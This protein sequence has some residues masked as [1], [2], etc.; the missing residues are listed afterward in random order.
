MSKMLTALKDRNLALALFGELFGVMLFQFLAGSIDV[1]IN[2]DTG[3]PDYS[4][5]TTVAVLAW[6][7]GIVF[8]VLVYL[9]RHTSGGHLNPV[10]TIAVTISGH[11]HIVKGILYI[12]VQ[13]VGGIIGAGGAHM[14]LSGATWCFDSQHSGFSGWWNLFGWEIIMTFVLIMVVYSAVITPGHGDVGP[15]VIGLTVVGCMWAGVPQSGA[16]LNPARVIAPSIANLGSDKRCQFDA[17]AYYLGAEVIAAVV[18]GVAALIVHGPGPHYDINREVRRGR[19]VGGVTQG[20]LEGES[21]QTA[22]GDDGA[23][24]ATV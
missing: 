6:G 18:A 7:N 22:G 23:A 9:T 21:A 4:D 17:F 20:L 5:P 11:M 16:P 3:K 8:A 10:V 1:P 14:F 2:P 24:P 12:I 13:I 15:L 19:A